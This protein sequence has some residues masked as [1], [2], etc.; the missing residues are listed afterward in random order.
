MNSFKKD[1][2]GKKRKRIRESEDETTENILEEYKNFEDQIKML[3]CKQDLI[4]EKFQ[5]ERKEFWECIH[6]L[7][8]KLYFGNEIYGK[9]LKD[10]ENILKLEKEKNKKEYII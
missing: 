9:N 1:L 3:S 2:T 6:N 7:E 10:M 4:F 5:K 8:K